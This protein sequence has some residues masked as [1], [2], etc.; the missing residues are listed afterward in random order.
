MGT[1]EPFL[2]EHIIRSV[3]RL[4]NEMDAASAGRPELQIQLLQFA[5]S[6]VGPAVRVLHPPNELG[7]KWALEYKARL[8]AINAEA[9]ART[10]GK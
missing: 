4:L 5:V 3:R 1:I 8:E 6:V 10:E 9:R 2:Q 7:A